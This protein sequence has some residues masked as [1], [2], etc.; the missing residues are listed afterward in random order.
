MKIRA[1]FSQE[2]C[3]PG[4]DSGNRQFGA[5]IEAE[6]VDLADAERIASKLQSAYTLFARKVGEGPGLGRGDVRSDNE[7]G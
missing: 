5:G 1:S 2:M 4:T 6:V 7:S 3:S